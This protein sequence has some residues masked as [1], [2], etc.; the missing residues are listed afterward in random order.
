[1]TDARVVIRSSGLMLAAAGVLYLPLPFLSGWT[2]IEDIGGSNW[3]VAYY[4]ATIHHFFLL[5]GLFGLFIVQ[6]RAAGLFGVIAFA[7]ASLGNA[8]VGGIGIVQITILP[9]F[10]ANPD[11]QPMLICTPFYTP[12]TA[13]AEGFIATACAAWNFDVLGMWVGAAWLSLLLGSIALGVAIARAGVLPRAAGLAL[14]VGWLWSA[15]ALF[16]PVPEYAANLGIAVVGAAYVACG[17]V[18]CAGAAKT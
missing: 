2:R 4:L 11:V 1:M 16:L 12:A 15:A 10:A 8:L 5:F 6:L 3:W 17:S 14:V 18:I 7:V 13:A 9:V